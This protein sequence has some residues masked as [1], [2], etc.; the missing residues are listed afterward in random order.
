MRLKKREIPIFRREMNVQ[1]G[2]GVKKRESPKEGDLTCMFILH[3]YAF[4]GLVMT[5]LM[6][7]I[8]TRSRLQS[9]HCQLD[10]MFMPSQ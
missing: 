7:V 8:S 9:I 6:K 4:L 2:D 1:E 10:Q 5:M 3:V